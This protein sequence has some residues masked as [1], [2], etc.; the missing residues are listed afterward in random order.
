M[1]FPYVIAIGSHK[2]GTGRTTTACALAWLW[3]QDG[4]RV[5]LADVDPARAARLI[6]L[7]TSGTCQ[8]SN[9][10]YRD[11]WPELSG[12]VRE[13]D[14]VIVDCPTLMDR[15]THEVLARC[16][17]IVLTCEAEPLS[18]RTAPAL[19]EVLP[20]ARAENPRLELMGLFISAY[21]RFDPIQAA[22]LETL[23]Q[24]HGEFMLEPAAPYD[25]AIRDWPLAPGAALPAGPAA[26][27]YMAVQER[28]GELAFQLHGA[29][30]GSR[31]LARSRA[32]GSC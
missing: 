15:R 9:V 3:G 8:W 2:G 21:N 17:A 30:L 27:A 13:S 14:L 6:A 18:L 31:Q 16:D 23:R 20:A 28:V 29:V 32:C 4:C 5:V 26:E 12:A 7:D 25:A 22:T 19:A 1:S 11:G 10:A 24:M